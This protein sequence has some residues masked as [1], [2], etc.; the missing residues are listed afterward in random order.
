[1]ASFHFVLFCL[2][3]FCSGLVSFSHTIHAQVLL[4]VGTALLRFI[5][6]YHVYLSFSSILEVVDVEGQGAGDG[7]GQVG[8]N[9]HQVHPRRPG[10]VLQKHVED[11]TCLP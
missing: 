6:F 7:E 9:G 2:D 3:Y 1:M 8:E 10:E 5:D 11:I 4:R